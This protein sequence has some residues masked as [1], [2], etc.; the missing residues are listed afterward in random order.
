MQKHPELESLISE[1]ISPICDKPNK[2][3]SHNLLGESF[4][5]MLWLSIA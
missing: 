1:T 4:I 5:T 2:T 3:S